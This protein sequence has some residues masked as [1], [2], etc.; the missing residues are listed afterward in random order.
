MAILTSL[1]RSIVQQAK[2]ENVISIHIDEA[3][4]SL[5]LQNLD[6]PYSLAR[7]NIIENIATGCDMPAK[8]LLQETFAE[9]FGEGS[10]DAKYIVQFIDRERETMQPLYDFMTPI[11]QH[12]AWT[13]GFYK[14]L[15]RDFQELKNKTYTQAFYEWQNSFKAEWPNLLREPESELVTR[16]QVK[17]QAAREFAQVI[18]PEADPVNK[19]IIVQWLADNVNENKMLFKNPLVLDMEAWKAHAEEKKAQDDEA[20]KA[21]MESAKEPKEPALKNDADTRKLVIAR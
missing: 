3:I 8:I 4:E 16:D 14:T 18:L 21:A 11:V 19:A 2:S 15:Q 6:A 7:K 9:G 12:R 20:K 17:L 10:E 5:N 1:K 13:E